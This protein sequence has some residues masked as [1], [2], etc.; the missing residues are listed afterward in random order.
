MRAWANPG[1]QDDEGKGRGQGVRVSS[2]SGI[3]LTESVDKV[4]FQMSFSAR[5][6]Q[7]ILCIG[8]NEGY[9]DAFAREL[10]YAKRLH[11]HFL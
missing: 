2:R 6:R 9:V 7:L 4:V 3:H 10:T 5:I 1:R 11:E 8:S